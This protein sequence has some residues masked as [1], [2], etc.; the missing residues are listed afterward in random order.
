M[1][2]GSLDR[3]VRSPLRRLPGEHG[4]TPKTLQASL[5]CSALLAALIYPAFPSGVFKS[6]LVMHCFTILLFS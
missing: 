1:A 4:G 3:S 5:I 2:L 6:G